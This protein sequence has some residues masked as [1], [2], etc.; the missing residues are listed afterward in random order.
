[1]R[2]PDLDWPADLFD[3]AASDLSPLTWCSAPQR[4]VNG[5]RPFWPAM[6]QMWNRDEAGATGYLRPA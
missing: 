1:M 2:V 4:P 6:L 5:V 3:D